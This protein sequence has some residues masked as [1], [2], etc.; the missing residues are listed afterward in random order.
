MLAQFYNSEI[1][2]N[3]MIGILIYVK[4]NIYINL[5]FN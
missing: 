1:S 2:A 3:F 5:F 4:L